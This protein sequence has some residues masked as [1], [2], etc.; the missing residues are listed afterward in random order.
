MPVL[1]LNSGRIWPN[2]PE[3]CVEVVEATTIDLSCAQRGAC[4]E[5]RGGG[6]D[7][8]SSERRVSMVSSSFAIEST[9]DKLAAR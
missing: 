7:A 4:A 3:S 1:A 6:G 5:Q 8:M 9:L 2:R